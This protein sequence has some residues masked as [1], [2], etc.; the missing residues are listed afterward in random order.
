MDTNERHVSLSE[1]AARDGS[2]AHSAGSLTQ[3]G[4]ASRNGIPAPGPAVRYH[5]RAPFYPDSPPAVD[6]ALLRLVRDG[7]FDEVMFFLPHVEERSPGLGTEEEV[8]ASVARVAPLFPQLR[9]MGVEPSVNVWWTMAFSDFPGARRDQRARGFAFRWAVNADG[10][11][12]VA[13]ACP[14]DGASQAHVRR[15]YARFAALRPARLWI[16]DDVRLTP[17]ADMHSPCFCAECLAEMRRR[18]GCEFT[19]ASLL[20][21][22]LADPPNAVRDAWLRYQQDLML[23]LVR[24]LERAVHAVSPETHLS[25]MVSPFEIH[26]PEGRRWGELVEALGRPT[27]YVRPPIGPHAD[28]NGMGFLEAANGS[29]LLRAA[30]PADVPL[31]PEIENYPH[32]R[33]AKSLATVRADLILGQ[34]YGLPEMTFSIQ[35]MSERLDLELRREDAWAGMLREVKPYLQQIAGLRIGR[36]QFRGVSLYFHEDVTRHVFDGADLARP[37]L[38]RRLRPW[39]VALPMLGV[40]TRYGAGDLTAFAGEQVL[41]LTADERRRVFSEGVLLDGRAAEALVRAGD[42]DLIGV[43]GR[44]ADSPGV[45]EVITDPAFGGLVGDVINLRCEGA[46]LQF[47]WQDGARVIS[48]LRDYTGS[49]VGPGVVLFENALGGRVAVAPFDSQQHLVSL[50]HPVNPIASAGFINWPRQ[51]QLLDILAWLGRGPLPLVVSGATGVLPLRIDQPGRVIVAVT[52][53]SFDPIAGLRFALADPGFTV[54]RVRALRSDAAWETLEAGLRAADGAL[55]VTTGLRVPFLE[56]A[57]LV[58]EA[59]T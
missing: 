31:A 3:A 6:E 19:R 55:H 24:G 28:A 12:S 2:S 10:R 39:D 44:L 51:A 11:E 58:L 35:R 29:R 56:T 17:R 50:G 20:K 38:L 52:N 7:R 23:D 15:M 13:V 14:R 30:L 32:S 43:Q 22:I 34:L 1:N 4:D 46:P 8:E 36:D 57:V 26:A 27:P 48:R 42:G 25:L 37:I 59:A 53:L 45:T 33:F 49:D 47:D 54:A 40:A 9:A 41:C 18:T 5:L 16:D 21:G